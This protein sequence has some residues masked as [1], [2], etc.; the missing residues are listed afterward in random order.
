MS[1][2]IYLYPLWIRL[3]HAL[4]A[5]LII[6][7]IISGVSMQY[8]NPENP[9]IRFDIAVTMHNISGMILTANYMAF[10]LG[11]FFTPNGKYYKLSFKG[12]F[13]RLIK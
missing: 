7:L 11:T 8:T 10:L 4:N 5:I 12:L 3:W 6:L 13:A 1:G 2:K 9:F